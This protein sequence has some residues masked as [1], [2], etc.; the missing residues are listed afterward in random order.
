MVV[1]KDLSGLD[2]GFGLGFRRGNWCGRG[3]DE[4]SGFEFP[5]QEAMQAGMELLMALDAVQ[6]EA[7]ANDCLE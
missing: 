6:I 5:V 1:I 3:C 2:W 7:H 4:G